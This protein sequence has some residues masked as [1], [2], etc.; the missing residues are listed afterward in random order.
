M[1]F[2][3]EFCIALFGKMS[4]ETTD[5]VKE[6]VVAFMWMFFLVYIA[7][8]L[9]SCR[10]RTIKSVYNSSLEENHGCWRC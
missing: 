4:T 9:E 1:F 3:V 10:P 7:D 6:V 5:H 8:Y 2:Y